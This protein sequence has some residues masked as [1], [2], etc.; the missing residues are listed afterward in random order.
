MK[1]D[2]NDIILVLRDLRKSGKPIYSNAYMLTASFMKNEK[3]KR[4]W[5]IEGIKDKHEAYLRI[6]QHQIIESGLYHTILGIKTFIDVV[7][8]LRSIPTIGA[9]LAY[10]YAQDLNYSNVLS[11]DDNTYCSAGFGTIRGIDRVFDIE[12]TPDYGEIVLWTHKNFRLLLHDYGFDHLFVALPNWDPHVPDL[13]NCFC[14]TDKYLRGLGITTLGKEI[15]GKR[16]KNTFIENKEPLDY[17]FPAKWN[18]KLK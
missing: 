14:E 15:Y 8:V 10:Q 13:S 3:V 7:E 6:Y 16:I 9:F 2:V 4:L 12:G 5:R 18:L 1:T 11:F 17:I